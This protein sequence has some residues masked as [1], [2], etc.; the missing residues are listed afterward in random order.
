MLESLLGA[1]FSN[2]RVV[3]HFITVLVFAVLVIAA[4]QAFP[5]SAPAGTVSVT[6]SAAFKPGAGY[7]ILTTA[8]AESDRVMAG[9]GGETTAGTARPQ[10]L[11][12]RSKALPPHS[13]L[14]P[15]VDRRAAAA[16]ERGHTS[17]KSPASALSLA[18]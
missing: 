14:S 4:A 5:Q 7:W 3:R 9:S 10:A 12:S 13:R 17:G 15:N 8:S 1:H 11:L 18:N 16:D 6:P 2:R